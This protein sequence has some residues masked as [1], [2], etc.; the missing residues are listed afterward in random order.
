MIRTQRSLVA[1]LGVLAA[2]DF[3]AA[4]LASRVSGSAKP[5]VP[6]IT[7]MVVVGVLTLAAMYGL[8]DP[9]GGPDP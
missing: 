4:V 3:I 1:M 7:A 9:R 5:P 8:G 2:L 6:A